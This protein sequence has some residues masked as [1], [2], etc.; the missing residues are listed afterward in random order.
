[1]VLWRLIGDL[2]F[3]YNS[4]GAHWELEDRFHL[5][6]VSPHLHQ[7]QLCG[8]HPSLVSLVMAHGETLWCL[9]MGLFLLLARTFGGSYK[10]FIGAH[11]GPQWL[12]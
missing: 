10:Y 8:G 6:S 9:T 1:M 7:F 5:Y 2:G 11:W 4:V 12:M 3:H